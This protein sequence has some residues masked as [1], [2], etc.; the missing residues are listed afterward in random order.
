MNTQQMR[1]QK[2]KDLLL[3][4]AEGAQHYKPNLEHTE[5]PQANTKLVKKKIEVINS[6][7]RYDIWLS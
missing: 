6:L 1:T 7:H 4:K 2:D 3:M 5:H